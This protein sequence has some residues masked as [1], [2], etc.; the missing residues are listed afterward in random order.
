MNQKT[1]DWE[2]LNTYLKQVRKM[3]H[4]TWKE[5][6]QKFNEPLL[7]EIEDCCYQISYEFKISPAEALKILK[8]LKSQRKI[9]LSFKEIF[10]FPKPEESEEIN[11]ALEEEDKKKRIKQ[12][13]ETLKQAEAWIKKEE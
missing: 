8:Y 2:N 4:K 13:E 5:R 12:A 3:F 7:M 11:L 1:E 10:Y 6:F 9:E